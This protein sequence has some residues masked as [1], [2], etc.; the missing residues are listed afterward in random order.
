MAFNA[1]LALRDVHVEGPSLDPVAT[2][3]AMRRQRPFTEL[4]PLCTFFKGALLLCCVH[5][6]LARRLPD[7]ID[8]ELARKCAK[9]GK[10]KSS[11]R[12]VHKG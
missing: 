9:L 10:R 6:P 1:A 5:T 11:D 7:L 3:G 2:S 4:W 8:R 12:E